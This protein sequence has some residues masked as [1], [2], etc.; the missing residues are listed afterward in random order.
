MAEA[1]TKKT[2][3]SVPAFL[4]AIKDD[5][6]RA[7]CRKLVAIMQA[8]TGQKP[9][10]WGTGLVGFG[11]Y[12]YVYASGREGDWPI[13][14]FAP[15]KQNLTVYVMP[16]FGEYQDLLARL[17]P[18]KTAVSCLYIKR[19]SDVHLPTLKKIITASVKQMKKKYPAA[20]GRPK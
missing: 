7:D 13:T 5:E 17:G 1:K 6:V 15:R 16:G 8:A 4:T 2:P 20:P 18:H 14:A 9:R 19:L 11:S 10:L 3:A 12:H